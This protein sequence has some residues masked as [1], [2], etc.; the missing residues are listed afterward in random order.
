MGKQKLQMLFWSSSGC[1]FIMSTAFLMMPIAGQLSEKTN[2]ISLFVVGVIF[3]GF[4]IAGYGL[5]F[6]AD[7]ERRV[8]I[9][10]HPKIDFRTRGHP[11]VIR[12]LSNTP[13]AIADAVMVTSLISFVI[14]QMLRVSNEYISFILLFLLAFSTNMHGMLNGRIYRT[15]KYIRKRRN[16]S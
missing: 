12:F 11:G 2:R 10:S 4:F 8:L 1:L 3:W 16:E 6:L 9:K 13:A 15:T 14:I 5:L 7:K